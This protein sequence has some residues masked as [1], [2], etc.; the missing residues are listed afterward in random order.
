MI[1]VYENG[2]TTEYTAEEWYGVDAYENDRFEAAM[3][4]IF[5]ADYTE[6]RWDGSREYEERGLD[7]TGIEGIIVDDD[8]VRVAEDLFTEGHA[9]AL[10]KAINDKIKEA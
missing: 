2:K 8:E 9:E 7:F 1:K 10:R 5:N 6:L 3:D 4:G